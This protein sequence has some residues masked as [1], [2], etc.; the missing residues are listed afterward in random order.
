MKIQNKY[1]KLLLYDCQ[2]TDNFLK[3]NVAICGTNLGLIQELF[4]GDKNIGR[5]NLPENMRSRTRRI[6]T[7]ITINKINES[8]N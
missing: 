6:L 4:L 2:L 7:N 3:A 8:N 5:F 1:G